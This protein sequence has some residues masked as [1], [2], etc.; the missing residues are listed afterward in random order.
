MSTARTSPSF[1]WV[2]AAPADGAANEAL[3]RLLAR[4]LGLPLS[5][6]RLVAGATTRS[7]L[8]AI[9]RRQRPRLME[10]WPGLVD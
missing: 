9:D 10:L 6:L 3:I 7:K 1:A 4:E 2:A 8:V 5:A